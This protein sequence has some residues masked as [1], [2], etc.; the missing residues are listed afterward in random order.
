VKTNNAGP[1]APPAGA[2]E[3][4]SGFCPMCQMPLE[5]LAESRVTPDAHLA[6]C[7]DRSQ[8]SER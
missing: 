5:L 6:D 3:R 8:D 1:V 4:L 7:A 2:G